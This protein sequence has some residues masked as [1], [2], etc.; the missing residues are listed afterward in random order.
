M[1]ILGRNINCHHQSASPDQCMAVYGHCGHNGGMAIVN[2]DSKWL[3]DHLRAIKE[4]F[5]SDFRKLPKF[6]PDVVHTIINH[7]RA[8][9][10]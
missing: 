4:L 8:G 1:V 5:G 6:G 10:T 2:N 7:F 3:S 9:A